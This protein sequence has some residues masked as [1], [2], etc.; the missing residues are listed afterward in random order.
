MGA[1][2]K[3]TNNHDISYIMLVRHFLQPKSKKVYTFSG[4][5]KRF[6]KRRRQMKSVGAKTLYFE[7]FTQF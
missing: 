7:N 6:L 5:E 3:I 4:P 2:S 1:V